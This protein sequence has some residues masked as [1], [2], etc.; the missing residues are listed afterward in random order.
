MQTVFIILFD[1]FLI[2]LIFGHSITRLFM[3]KRRKVAVH[4]RDYEKHLTH[5]L[6]RNR[7]ILPSK[8]IGE[9]HDVIARIQEHRDS[10][11]EELEGFSIKLRA[12]SGS[13]LPRAS[14]PAVREYLEVLIVAIS[15]A[16]GIRGLF[17]QPFK[18]PTGSM[19]PTL[20][21]IHADPIDGDSQ[22]GIVKRVLDYV[23]YSRRYADV[24]IKESGYVDS[25]KAA[26][27]GIPFFP[28]TKINI[29]SR[30]YRLPGDQDALKKYVQP[31]RVD[32][33]GRTYYDKDDV[34]AESMLV[35]GDHL[36]V[37]RTRYCFAE[38]QRGDVTVFLTDGIRDTYGNALGGRYYIKRLV[39]LPGDTLRITSRK[40]YV[41]PEGE[42]DFR[43]VDGSDRPAFD[44]IHAQEGLYR[45]YCHDSRGAYLVHDDDT[46]TVPEGHYFMLGDN[47]ENSRDSRFWGTV[48][49]ENLVGRACLVWWPFSPRWGV[50]DKG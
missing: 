1:A 20:Y 33:F 21:G 40:L 30:P 9:I 42:T 46:F 35:L 31:P 38:P 29:G 25:V 32:D 49:R 39:G 8:K 28:A 11:G 10:S 44:R 17:L 2:Y 24:K 47:T 23:H 14:A 7:D 19:Q 36:F 41:R 4:L 43:P 45:G 12:E 15:L 48:P 6:R 16:F 34:L 5:Y 37:D 13:L 27:P 26:S 50:V 22:P 18:I 3:S